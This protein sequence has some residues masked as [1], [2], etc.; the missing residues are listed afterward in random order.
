M[1]VNSKQIKWRCRRGVLELDVIL[2]RFYDKKFDALSKDD[3][4]LFATM[5]EEPDPILINWLIKRE[6]SLPKFKKLTEEILGLC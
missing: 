1:N 4:H 5:L 3:K 2:H 6:P